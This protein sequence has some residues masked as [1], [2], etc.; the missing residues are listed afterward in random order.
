MISAV[1][2]CARTPGWQLAAANSI[3]IQSFT[4]KA[5]RFN[6]K[7]LVQSDEQSDEQSN[8]Q[9]NEQSN[10]QANG[11]ANEQ[12]TAPM[13]RSIVR[14]T[15]LPVSPINRTGRTMSSNVIACI[16][17][18]EMDEILFGRTRYLY[19]KFFFDESTRYVWLYVRRP[20]GK[21]SYVAEIG[22]CRLVPSELDLLPYYKNKRR[23]ALCEA[24]KSRMIERKA[25]EGS[26]DGGIG[27]L[28]NITYHSENPR[29][30]NI[31]DSMAYAWDYLRGAVGKG[32]LAVPATSEIYHCPGSDG[33]VPAVGET[34]GVVLRAWIWFS[35]S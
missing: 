34:E 9:A 18:E 24:D 4:A 21:L 28:P 6:E 7:P 22:G 13:R 11:Q 25:G 26:A 1:S 31:P 12:S 27:A 17:E 35:G 8:G 16:S 19:R 5:P 15:I 32:F 10:G 3:W 30:F 23:E 2:R 14:R 20:V 33:V 29:R